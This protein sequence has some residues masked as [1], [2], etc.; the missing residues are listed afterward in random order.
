M[1]NNVLQEA[2]FKLIKEVNEI[3]YSILTKKISSVLD[4]KRSFLLLKK[5]IENEIPQDL[6]ITHEGKQVNCRIELFEETEKLYAVS[7]RFFKSVSWGDF[8]KLNQ[9]KFGELYEMMVDKNG[10]LLRTFDDFKGTIAVMD[11][12]G[13]TKFSN[14]VKYNKTPL[15]E[16]GNILPQKIEHICNLCKTIVYEIEGDA[17]ILIG[18]ENPIY[19][20]NAVLSIIELARQKSL[21]SNINP[22]TF[23]NIEIK[24]P[25]IKPFEMNAAV[26]TGGETFINRKGNIIGTVISEASRIL[27]IINTKKPD[28]SGVIVSEKIYRKL[29]K[30]R[31]VKTD[32]HLS[33]FDFKTSVPTL[34]DVK[35]MRLNI[36]EIY[37]ED[38]EYYPTIEV[39]TLNLIDEIKKKTA[40]KWFNIFSYYIKVILASCHDL[41]FSIQIGGEELNQDKVKFI[42]QERLTIWVKEPSSE[43]IKDVLK[44]SSALFGS[45]NEVRDSIAIFFE[46]IQENFSYIAEKLENF[47]AEVLRKEES[48]PN[49][50]KSVESYNLEIKKAKNR[51][52]PR[53][54]LETILSD[55]KFVNELLDIPYMGKK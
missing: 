44:I 40:A 16:F 7:L 8:S 43:V 20:L 46:Y 11:F 52:P 37:I 49:F 9:K 45:I 19:I 51:I 23:H 34:V 30:Y 32:C 14:E 15:L 50:K 1:D 18:P 39:H 38:R 48:N 12:H 13:Y 42:L 26:T 5:Q 10:D 28:K 54:I 25:M 31:D 29:D 53:R 21:N 2:L 33:V 3:N 27:K 41:K 55:Q 22:K 36:R 35:G 24:N 4:I 17:L 47:Y 6:K